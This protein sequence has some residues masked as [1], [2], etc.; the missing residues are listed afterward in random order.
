MGSVLR[1]R[2]FGDLSTSGTGDFPTPRVKWKIEFG[3]IV[4]D[5]VGSIYLWMGSDNAPNE[6]IE[7]AIFATTRIRFLA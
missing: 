6:F 4:S 2:A 1:V 7:M 3:V 5:A